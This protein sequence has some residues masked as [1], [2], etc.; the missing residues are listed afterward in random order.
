MKRRHDIF[1]AW[2]E[3]VPIPQKLRGTCYTEHVFLHP[4]GYVAHVVH[5]GARNADALFFKL[6][7]DLM[8]GVAQSSR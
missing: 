7:W 5:S 6:E 8:W 4:A 2:M 3:L 1:H